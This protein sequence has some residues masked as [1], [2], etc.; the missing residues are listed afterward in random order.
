M[1]SSTT[2]AAGPVGTEESEAVRET[3]QERRRRETRRRILVAALELFAERGFE[4]V[5]VEEIADRADVARGTVFNHFTTKDSLCEAIGELQVELLREAVREGRI[6]G[7]SSGEKIAQAMRL[8]AAFPSQSPEHCRTLLVRALTHLRPGELN[9]C[10][11]QLFA[12]FEG[13]VAEGQR[14]GELR[15]DLPSCEL[16]GFMMGLRFQ[17]TLL[18]AYG[19]AQGSLADHT[20]RVLRLALE[21]IRTRPLIDGAAG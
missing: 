5:T 2:I 10:A 18:W 14:S 12:M 8:L 13:W 9:E 7:P 4:A 19:F 21:G 1:E 11:R 15:A 6:H 20:E 17:A 16:A 3:R